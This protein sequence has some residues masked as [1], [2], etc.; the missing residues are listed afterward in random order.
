A[1]GPTP[2]AAFEDARSGPPDGVMCGG[3]GQFLSAGRTPLLG[4]LDPGRGDPHPDQA[5]REIVNDHQQRTREGDPDCRA[6][7]PPVHADG[8]ADEQH[9]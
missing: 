8:T 4:L 1:L 2:S 6:G 5:L 3:L 9:R 7:T